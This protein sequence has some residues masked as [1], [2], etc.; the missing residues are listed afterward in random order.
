ME[1]LLRSNLQTL[2]KEECRRPGVFREDILFLE[3]KLEQLDKER[4]H[5]ALVRARAD[6]LIA[7]ET[8]TKRALSMEKKYAHR[9]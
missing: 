8:P 3:I 6:R 4:Y 2:V 9:E 1:K 7:G 5:G